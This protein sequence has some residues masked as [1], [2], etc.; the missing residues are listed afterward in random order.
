M[1]STFFSI[2]PLEGIISANATRHIFQQGWV[3]PAP[4]EM[5]VYTY[6]QYQL[7]MAKIL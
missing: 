3:Q 6:N 1:I 7:G 2:S 4:I 5:G